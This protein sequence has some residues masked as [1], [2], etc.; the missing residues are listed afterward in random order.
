MKTIFGMAPKNLVAAFLIAITAAALLCGY[1]FARSSAQ[2]IFITTYGAKYLPHA[3]AFIPVMAIGM[4]YGYGWLLS[5]FG[6]RRSFMISTLTC[7]FIFVVARQLVVSGIKPAAIFL[8]LF[9]ETYVMLLV[10][11][12]W[13]LINSSNIAKE[14]RVLYGPICGIAALGSVAGGFAVGNLS[15]SM[16]TGNLPLLAAFSLIFTACL[17]WIM[18]H[19]IGEPKPELAEEKLGKDHSGL[20]AFFKDRRLLYLAIV[21]MSAQAIAMVLDIQLSHYVQK[22]ILEQDLR[23]RWFGNF[24][25][26]LN[27]GSVVC[28]FIVAPFLIRFVSL[29]KIHLGIPLLHVVVIGV[30]IFVPSLRTAAVALCVFK[31]VDY[32]VFRAAKELTY[33]P[34]SFDV[35]YRAKQ[36]IDVFG[37]RSAKGFVS[38]VL[39]LLTSL[40]NMPVVGYGISALVLAG[41]W[42]VGA[43]RLTGK[44]QNSKFK[45]QN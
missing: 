9:K 33:V 25:G 20:K 8:F 27:L 23:T 43:E 1:E 40:A 24:Y 12:M 14:A 3:M 31:V 45:I 41:G 32:S 16:G 19:F 4:V 38:V 17:G 35:R 28:Q 29:R 34:F 44:I 6:A 21:V 42:L 30:S 36:L 2:S 13:S 26:V 15:V 7:S 37:Y 39:A 5:L 11:Q 10:E 22:T 18:F